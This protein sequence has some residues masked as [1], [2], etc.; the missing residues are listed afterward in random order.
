LRTDPV[1]KEAYE[2]FKNASAKDAVE[3]LMADTEVGRALRGNVLYYKW[4]N[5]G[6]VLV[7]KSNLLTLIEI[8]PK[9]TLPSPNNEE[10]SLRPVFE[11]AGIKAMKQEGED[12]TVY[13]GMY[14]TQYWQA[15]TGKMVTNR[16]EFLNL[17]KQSG[18][19]SPND[20]LFD[21]EIVAALKHQHGK[22]PT[23]LKMAGVTRFL[24]IELIKEM[25]RK[26]RPV[27]IDV[28]GS[29]YKGH[30]VLCIGFTTKDGNT[31]FH[32]IDSNGLY[33][34]HGYKTVPE[35]GVDVTSDCI[36]IE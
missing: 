28:K 25:I 11:K 36:W 21:E 32:Y 31:T 14:L 12:C 26:G 3:M 6:C 2:K 35:Y 23:V 24:L 9:L 30:R 29:K 16:N 20:V 33:I 27:L 7:W 10:A 18:K 19:N 22:I 5:G 8:A 13:A 1:G 17:L 15:T 34:D 4:S